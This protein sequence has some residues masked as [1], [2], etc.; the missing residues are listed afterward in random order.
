MTTRKKATAAKVPAK[1]TQSTSV[2]AGGWRER[3]A[4]SLQSGKE[5]RSMLP[6]ASG[7][8]ISFRNGDITL[9]GVTL[10]NPLPVVIL[11]YGYERSYYSRPYQPDTLSTPD[12]YSY[13]N[14]APHPESP[15]AQ[16]ERCSNCR[17]N[18]FGSAINGKGKGCKEGARLVMIHADALQSAESVAKTTIVQAKV[19]VLNSKTFS[20]YADAV[21]ARG[22][23]LWQDVTQ[24]TNQQDKKSQYAVSFRLE[25]VTLDDDIL[26][27]IALRVDEAEKLLV[28]PY[29]EVEA[30]KPVAP[31]RTRTRQ[32]KF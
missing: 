30:A 32:R 28:Q 25:G 18:D 1:R 20:A 12:C 21:E 9:G 24:I 6:Q 15:A 5:V 22:T 16:S 27:A 2:V 4:K 3:A 11:A 14:V 7:N 29:P 31:P 10:E 26:D 8:F 23:V 17:F 13:D 19:S